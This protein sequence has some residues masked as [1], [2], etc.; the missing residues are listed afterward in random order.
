MPDRR[1]LR[2]GIGSTIISFMMKECFMINEISVIGA[3]GK[4]GSWFTKYLSKRKDTHLLLYDINPRFQR[5]KDNYTICRNIDD[6]VGNADIVFLCVPVR[7]TPVT[8]KQ[9]AL[10]MKSGAILAEISSVKYQSF[11]VLKKISTH[12]RP[13]CIHPMF[14]PGAEEIKN[15]N[16]L[17]IPV[18]DEKA[19]TLVSKYLFKDALITVLPNAKI[20]DELIALVLGLTHYTNI[21]FGSFLS[22]ENFNLLKKVSGTTFGLQSLLCRSIFTDEPDLI[23]ALLSENPSARKYI[24]NYVNNASKFAKLILEGNESKIKAHFQKIRAI[25]EQQQNLELSY[26]RMYYL[27]KELSK[28]NNSISA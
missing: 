25:L 20:H 1:S 5:H 2:K 23:V 19:E 16:I 28:H 12:I 26:Q 27:M 13:L 17:L 6:C 21:I 22:K 10:R 18:Q 3:G 11:K 15:M 4:M 14:G 24:Q 8:L 7:N 9:C